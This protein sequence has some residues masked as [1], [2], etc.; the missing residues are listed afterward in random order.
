MVQDDFSNRTIFYTNGRDLRQKL[1]D[2]DPDIVQ[3]VEPFALITVPAIYQ[4]CRYV[5]HKSKPLVV[6][7]LENLPYTR[8]YGPV[9]W[10]LAPLVAHYIQLAQFIF[11][12]NEGARQNFLRYHARPERMCRLLY[13][14]WGV[15]LEEYSPEGDQA[16]LPGDAQ[17]IILFVGRIHKMKGVFDLL[18]AFQR[19]AADVPD[20]NLMFIGSGSA[21]SALQ[22]Q[23]QHYGL[24]N[25]VQFLGTIKNRYIAQYMR[26]ATLFVSPAVTTWLWAEQIGMT[27][28]QALGCGVPVVSTTSGSIAEFIKHNETGLLVPEHDPTA[29]AQA[30]YQLLTDP[31]LHA[32][33]SARARS[34]ALEHYDA[35]SNVQRAEHEIIQRC[36]PNKQLERL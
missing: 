8:K 18:D 14:T 34:Y 35:Q 2:L 25:R 22:Q 29:L 19:I 32:R 20:V 1:E 30:M 36:V 27:M 24:T 33:L 9:A 15:D 17:R 10:M 23:S 7:S 21:E 28:I 4:I 13:G 31:A 16:E 3:G 11:Y 6:G 26:R 12:V 5:V